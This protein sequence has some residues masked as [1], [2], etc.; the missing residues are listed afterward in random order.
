MFLDL[1]E[2]QC[3]DRS[4]KVLRCHLEVESHVAENLAASRLIE[5]DSDNENVQGLDGAPLEVLY[6]MLIA[7]VADLLVGS[8]IVIVPDRSLF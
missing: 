6:D 2:G 7:P 4:L 1:L 8:E 5:E 3:E